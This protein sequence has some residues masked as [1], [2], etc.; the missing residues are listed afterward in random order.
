M[1]SIDSKGKVFSIKYDNY[2]L[3]DNILYYFEKEEDKNIYFRKL[4]IEKIL[5]K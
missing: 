4:K 3:H 5:N 1:L 2:Y